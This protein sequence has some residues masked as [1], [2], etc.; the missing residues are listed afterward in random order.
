[1]M[2]PEQ[3]V[4]WTN[5][6]P[7][8]GSTPMGKGPDVPDHLSIYTRKEMLLLAKYAVQIP[9]GGTALEIGV[10]VGHTASIL[11]NLQGDL[12]LN[13]FLIDNW[14][15]MM[16]DAKDSFDKMMRDN[17]PLTLYTG[18]WGTS[19]EAR[20]MW[21]PGWPID[22]IHIDG[23]H[24][25]GPDGVDADCQMWLPL[26]DSGGVV[27]FHDADHLPVWETIQEFCPGWAGERAGR[28][29]VRVK[30]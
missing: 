10:Y 7:E 1:M 3:L 9:V 16:P 6:V 17:F 28:T 13:V 11:L 2:T 23:N 18:L 22:F 20:E 12:S 4:D 19:K 14:S 5:N 24:D 21:S 25:R 27:A 30:P 8:L 29:V 26:L 15:W